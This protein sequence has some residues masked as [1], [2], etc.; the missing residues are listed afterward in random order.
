MF[1]KLNIA[2]LLVLATAS[3]AV[4]AS[5]TAGSLAK[6]GDDGHYDDGHYDDGHYDDG[7]YDD[8]H[9]DNGHYDNGRK[10]DYGHKDEYYRL[11]RRG[12]NSYDNDHNDGYGHED[13]GYGYDHRDGYGY[14]HRDNYDHDHKDDY[15]HEDDYGHKDESYRLQRRGDDGY[16][17]NTWEAGVTVDKNGNGKN[18][19]SGYCNGRKIEQ[20]TSFEHGHGHSWNEVEKLQR[21]GDDGY[22]RNTWEGGVAN[23]GYGNGANWQ[24]GYWNGRRVEQA[25]GYKNGKGISWNKVEGEHHGDATYDSHKDDGKY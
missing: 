14:D 23:D 17:H 4:L 25:T 5:P 18:W 6:R 20:G 12:D 11:A 22:G 3:M 8:G 15:G 24:G 10:D 19:Q 13:H 2:A 7:H 1:G 16:G 21:R 9:Y